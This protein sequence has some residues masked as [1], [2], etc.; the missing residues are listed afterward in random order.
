MKYFTHIF[1][2]VLMVSCTSKS[3]DSTQQI[4]LTEPTKNGIVIINHNEKPPLFIRGL[5]STSF[6][7]NPVKKI[8]FGIDTLYFTNQSEILKIS[9]PENFTHKVLLQANDTLS[10]TFK[11]SI[12]TLSGNVRYLDSIT[13]K[14]EKINKLQDK[15]NDLNDRY[16]VQSELGLGT[17]VISNEY[18]KILMSG[19]GGGYYNNDLIKNE[20]DS[21]LKLLN[22]YDGLKIAKLT[23]ITNSAESK[24]LN[25]S[26]KALLIDKVI[27]D[28]FSNT[29]LWLPYLDKETSVKKVKEQLN[30]EVLN[31]RYANSIFHSS[32]NTLQNEYSIKSKTKKKTRFYILYDKLPRLF[33]GEL[34]QVAKSVCIDKMMNWNEPWIEIEK[35]YM[36]YISNYGSDSYIRDFE[37]QNSNKLGVEV[38]QSKDLSLATINSNTLTLNALIEKHKGKP[39]YVDYWASWCAPCI[40]NMPYSKK[41]EEQLGDDVVFIF[42]SIDTNEKNWLSS[43][44]KLKLPDNTSFITVNYDTSDFIKEQNIKEIPRYMIYDKNGKLYNDK[45]HTPRDKELYNEL[46]R[47]TQ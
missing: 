22:H 45:A 9:S 41:L 33:N 13:L 2:I 7:K 10:V 31:N 15:I 6:P 29:N 34:L 30:M 44:K 5:P 39:I 3:K 20:R 12:I 32:L 38:T 21:I 28:Y 1:I 40:A 46:L 4:D 17:F 19:S 27:L 18:E 26:S 47:L 43:S 8:E 16:F 42:I 25:E 23:E 37:E 14:N 24:N 36:D 35:C 11:D